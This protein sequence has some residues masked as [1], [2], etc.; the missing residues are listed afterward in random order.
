VVAAPYRV[1]VILAVV[2]SECQ[3]SQEPIAACKYSSATV[4]IIFQVM[5]EREWEGRRFTLIHYVIILG[6]PAR[7]CLYA[8][9]KK[10][11]KECGIRAAV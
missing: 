6:T 2:G 9:L 8:K 1:L 5:P 4:K 11:K 3:Y 7:I 10:K